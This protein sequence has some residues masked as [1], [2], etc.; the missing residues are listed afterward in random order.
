MQ[1]TTKTDPKK[2]LLAEYRDLTDADHAVTTVIDEARDPESGRTYR[3]EA[4][5]AG[6]EPAG[7]CARWT[8]ACY[9]VRVVL[10]DGKTLS[11]RYRTYA[12]ARELFDRRTRRA[13]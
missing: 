12:E 11:H 4:T 13:Q 8:R 3:L 1:T 9:A 2:T 6:Y 7:S 5:T 10:P